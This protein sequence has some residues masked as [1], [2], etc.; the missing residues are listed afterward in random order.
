VAV[1]TT[2]TDLT[3][4]AARARR[5]RERFLQEFTVDRVADAMADL[6]RH[7]LAGRGRPAPAAAGRRP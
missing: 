5:A 7:A 6:Y 2:L 3:G 4:A 1:T